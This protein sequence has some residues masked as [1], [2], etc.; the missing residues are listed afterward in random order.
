[1]TN[2]D[3]KLPALSGLAAEYQKHWNDQYL[4]GIW[5]RQL[6]RQL[7]W[8]VVPSRN[9]IP[10]RPSKYRAP[11]WSWASTDGHICFEPIED[12]SKSFVEVFWSLPRASSLDLRGRISKGRIGVQGYVEKCMHG[13]FDAVERIDFRLTDDGSKT[14]MLHPDA[15][16]PNVKGTADAYVLRLFEKFAILLHPVE[17]HRAVVN[18]AFS[19]YDTYQGTYERLASVHTQGWARINKSSKRT[20]WIV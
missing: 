18:D 10:R 12:K 13:D 8:Y 11:S 17:G 15:F 19:H 16:L 1:M 2:E 3:D 5:Q 6:W 14:G 9:C 7:Q 4:A 20:I